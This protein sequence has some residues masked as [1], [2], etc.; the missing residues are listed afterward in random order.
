[1]PREEPVKFLV[2]RLSLVV[3]MCCL[4]ACGGNTVQIVNEG[5]VWLYQ[6][7]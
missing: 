5:V 1:M 7:A 3:V 2:I 6:R 4:P